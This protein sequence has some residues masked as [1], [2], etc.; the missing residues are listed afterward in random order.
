MC[1]ELEPELKKV[2]VGM[3]GMRP[4]GIE[5]DGRAFDSRFRALSPTDCDRCCLDCDCDWNAAAIDDL[6]RPGSAI[7]NCFGPACHGV[8][9]RTEGDARPGAFPGTVGMVLETGRV[10]SGSWLG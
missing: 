8:G 5:M 9:S 7:K 1:G 2:G 6:N 4:E 3:L 10:W